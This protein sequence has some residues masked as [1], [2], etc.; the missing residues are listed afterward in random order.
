MPR[1]I[2]TRTVTIRTEWEAEDPKEAYEMHIA[3]EWDAHDIDE[4]ETE[5]WDVTNPN[6]HQKVDLTEWNI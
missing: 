4:Q 3:N 6:L 1:Y 2:V 5:V